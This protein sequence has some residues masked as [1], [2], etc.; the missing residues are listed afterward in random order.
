MLVQDM[1][2]N[3]AARLLVL[4]DGQ[5]PQ[6]TCPVI[7]ED[8][9]WVGTRS[10]IL[11]GVTIG[12]HSVIAAGSVVRKEVPPYSLMAGNPARRVA[13]VASWDY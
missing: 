9:V 6:M 13:Q 3:S 8:D 4:A 1:L 5:R 12:H 2:H 11:K 10:L 7:I